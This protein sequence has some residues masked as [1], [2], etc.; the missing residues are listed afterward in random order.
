MGPRTIAKPSSSNQAVGVDNKE[1]P[2]AY[3]HCGFLDYADRKI[4]R[5]KSEE[6]DSTRTGF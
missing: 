5:S 3:E 2:S 4:E 6:K 1:L